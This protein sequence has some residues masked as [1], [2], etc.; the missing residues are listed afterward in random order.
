MRKVGDKIGRSKTVYGRRT[1]ESESVQEIGKKYNKDVTQVLR[2]ASDSSVDL[3]WPQW[4]GSYFVLMSVSS[5][6]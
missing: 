1:Y 4:K 6:V 3:K 5:K 2:D